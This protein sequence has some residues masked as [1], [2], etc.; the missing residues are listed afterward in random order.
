ME[1]LQFFREN[2]YFNLLYIGLELELIGIWTN[3]SNVFG[4][5]VFFL[6]NKNLF[7]FFL[8]LG[9]VILKELEALNP[10]LSIKDSLFK[11][12]SRWSI[13]KFVWHVSNLILLSRSLGLKNVLVPIFK[14]EEVC[15]PLNKY[16]YCFK[17]W[18][19]LLF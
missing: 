19:S 2:P 6:V 12:D 4:S 1:F 17:I 7:D 5:S 14:F 15:S 8:V 9:E 13:E 16:L 18:F 11:S 3:V 10:S